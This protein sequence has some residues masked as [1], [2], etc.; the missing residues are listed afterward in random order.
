[1]F[2][3]GRSLGQVRIIDLHLVGQGYIRTYQS[4]HI[5]ECKW[6]I[7]LCIWKVCP[8]TSNIYVDCRMEIKS[9]FHAKS[10]II[11][12]LMDVVL[13]TYVHQNTKHKKD[14]IQKQNV[15]LIASSYHPTSHEASTISS[16]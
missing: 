12:E 6:K 5:N 4:I 7:N 11:S 15:L 1:M 16:E 2:R 3:S 14:L 9:T 13:H 10:L 8:K